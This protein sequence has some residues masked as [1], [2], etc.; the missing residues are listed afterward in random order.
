MQ[1]FIVGIVVG[2]LVTGT[3]SVYAGQEKP[4]K[5]ER[6]SQASVAGKTPFSTIKA[7]DAKVKTA[8]PATDLKTAKALVGKSG[9]FVGTVVKVFAPKSNSV[10][11]LN[12]ANDYKAALVGAVDDKDFAKLP[13]LQKLTG[14][15]VLLTGKVVDYKG[16]PQ[17]QIDSPDDVRVVE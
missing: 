11:L 4:A 6:L 3:A 14:K 13:D 9:A 12:F 8:K 16:Q 1:K 5:K 15:K 2:L 17:I 7:S 10:V